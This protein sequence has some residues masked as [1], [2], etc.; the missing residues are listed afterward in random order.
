MWGHFG[1]SPETHVLIDFVHFDA[2]AER[3]LTFVLCFDLL[4]RGPCV[5]AFSPIPSGGSVPPLGGSP[6]PPPPLRVAA[7]LATHHRPFDSGWDPGGGRRAAAPRQWDE[8]RQLDRGAGWC[9][10]EGPLA[11]VGAS[12]ALPLPPNASCAARR[13]LGFFFRNSPIVRHTKGRQS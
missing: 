1:F 5:T 13:Y 7:P 3:L 10:S 6:S 12:L 4:S 8:P 11:S 9:F 2:D